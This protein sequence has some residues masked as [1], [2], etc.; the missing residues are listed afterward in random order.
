MIKYQ[1]DLNESLEYPC[2]LCYVQLYHQKN[3]N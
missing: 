2:T 1:M 3:K